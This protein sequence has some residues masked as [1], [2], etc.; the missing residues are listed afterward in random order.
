[1]LSIQASCGI[2]AKPPYAPSP[3]PGRFRTDTVSQLRRRPGS[4]ASGVRLRASPA[5]DCSGLQ[6]VRRALI[7][8]FLDKKSFFPCIS[9]SALAK[10]VFRYH[11]E[12][13]EESVGSVHPVGCSLRLTIHVW[14]RSWP[15]L[16]SLRALKV[17]GARMAQSSTSEA[18][19]AG[20]PA[21]L[22]GNR[23]RPRPGGGWSKI[24]MLE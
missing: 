8:V 21:R 2:A 9:Y 22:R 19:R 6:E 16:S 15:V 11:V 10:V 17:V 14:L 5:D 18:V 4:A 1:M 20:S 7:S 12:G 24:G 3:Y 23:E 13:T